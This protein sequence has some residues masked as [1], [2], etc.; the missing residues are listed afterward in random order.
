MKNKEEDLKRYRIYLNE[1]SRNTQ[2][3][4]TLKNGQLRKTLFYLSFY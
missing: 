1:S 4:L 3:A 2:K